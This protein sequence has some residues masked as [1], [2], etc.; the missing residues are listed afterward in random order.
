MSPIT[1]KGRSRKANLANI[2]SRA[3]GKN[4]HPK[5]KPLLPCIGPITGPNPLGIFTTNQDLT[6]FLKEKK[7]RVQMPNLPR[8]PLI[9]CQAWAKALVMVLVIPPL[10]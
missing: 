6:S 3:K 1:I 8:N 5:P 10:V 2:I 4:N 7:E 9:H